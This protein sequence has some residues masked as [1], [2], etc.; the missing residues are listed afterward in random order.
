MSQSFDEF[1]KVAKVDTDTLIQTARYYIA[2]RTDDPTEEEMR[3]RL[4]AAAGDAGAVDAAL[5]ALASDAVMLERVSD[6]VLRGAWEDPG[7]AERIRSAADDAKT[8]LPVIET[9]MI[10]MVAMYGMY[11]HVTGGK[12]S[13]VIDKDGRRRTEW[14]PHALSHLVALFRGGK[15]TTGDSSGRT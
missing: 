11:L 12:K 2:E 8:S 7:Q 5:A 1:V 13:E 10:A 14:Y 9:A 4:V 6:E 15:S 3:S